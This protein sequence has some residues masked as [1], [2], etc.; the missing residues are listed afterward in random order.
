[1]WV[2]SVAKCVQF[3]RR[4]GRKSGLTKKRA[5]HGLARRLRQRRA[6][7]AA[8]GSGRELLDDARW[9]LT[10][11]E[12]RFR[13]L[14]DRQDAFIVQRDERGCVTYANEAFCDAFGVVL[15]EVRGKRFCPE[16]VA[17]EDGGL[18]GASRVAPIE[19]YA[20][21]TGQRWVQWE[22]HVPAR[23]ARIQD[24]TW[25]GRDV[26]AERRAARD[27]KAARDQADAGSRAKSRFLAAMSHE[28][29]TPMNGILG[30]AGLLRETGLSADQ[31]TY[32]AAIDRSARTLLSIINEILDFSKIE[33]GKLHLF[34]EQFT[35]KSA[36]K[37]AIDLVQV[38]AEEKGNRIALTIDRDVSDV[39]LGDEARFGQ[40]LLN[41]LSNAVKFTRDGRID[42][43]VRRLGDGVDGDGR[44]VYVVEVRDTG[45][46]FSPEAMTVLFNEFEQAESTTGRRHG[47]T[48]LGLAISKRLAKAMG[49]DVLAEGALGKGAKFTV[50][51]RFREVESSAA[52]DVL[53]RQAADAGMPVSCAGARILVTE[54]NDI[55]ALLARRICERAGAIVTAAKN[56]REAVRLMERHLAGENEGFDLILMD[57]F[58]PE[59][60]GIEACRAVKDLF[61]GR[62]LPPPPVV[63]L[64]AHAFAEDRQRCL[65]AGMDDYLSKP[66]DV[67][68]LQMIVS[69]WVSRPLRLKAG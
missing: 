33:A 27:L 39:L 61:R 18:L 11:T 2:K 31:T 47:G 48:G 46:G 44:V 51:L 69:K 36:L 9:Q 6:V 13:E 30:M 56:G 22:T 37:S 55:N 60:D 15:D 65:E 8:A 14:F 53:R 32:L 68:Q 63:A 52:M 10:E 49:G 16:L 26:T 20:T 34:E 4:K 21:P 28:I 3:K 41:L 23:G 24:T 45:I 17:T 59:M 42:V 40:I 1:M 43:I 5:R 67:G 66:F 54:D 64:T 25:I 35:L 29:R 62:G 12:V 50:F 7:K 57:V 38:K 19:L 58:M